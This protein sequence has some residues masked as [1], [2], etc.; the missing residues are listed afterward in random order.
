MFQLKDYEISI[1]I[2]EGDKDSADNE[3]IYIKAKRL[4]KK[5]IHPKNRRRKQT[6]QMEIDF[7]D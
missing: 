7:K 4:D 3:V 5:N 6:E 1:G 2:V